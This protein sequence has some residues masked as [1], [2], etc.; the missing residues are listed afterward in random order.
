MPKLIVVTGIDGSGKTTLVE[1]LAQNIPN[2]VIANA[3]QCFG[4]NQPL[5]KSKEHV[6]EYMQTLTPNSRV[7]FL[8][9]AVRY[10]LE[11]ALAT[12]AE[13]V[14]IDGYY[15][16]Y[17]GPELA[18]GADLN[19]IKGLASSFP[20]PDKIICLELSPADA[21]ARKENVFTAY[22]CGYN[23][24][25][26]PATFMSFQNQVLEQRENFNTDNWIY[27]SAENDIPTLANNTLERL[28]GSLG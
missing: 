10:G 2:S 26:T 8:A 27:I 18:L 22:E 24:H 5:F 19:L 20:K 11:K 25:I 6:Y 23:M 14:L 16:K 9:H 21:S 7:L 3:W 17:F 12:N 13:T 4:D 15:F 1:A 28:A